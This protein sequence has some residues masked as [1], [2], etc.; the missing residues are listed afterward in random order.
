MKEGGSFQTGQEKG[1]KHVSCLCMERESV[2]TEL[3]MESKRNAMK[4]ILLR[5]DKETV[6]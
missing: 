3:C 4:S 5:T 1:E 6:R 2:Y